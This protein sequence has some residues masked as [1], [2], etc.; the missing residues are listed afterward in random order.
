M[1]VHRP[2]EISFFKGANRGTPSTC[3]DTLI[4]ILVVIQEQSDVSIIHVDRQ[5]FAVLA[6]PAVQPKARTELQR[7]CT[8]TSADPI[9]SSFFS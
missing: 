9:R 7:A 6:I 8:L 3:A 5:P 1:G 2:K 4:E